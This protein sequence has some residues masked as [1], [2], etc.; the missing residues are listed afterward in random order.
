MLRIGG[1]VS[2]IRR[3]AK[4]LYR[5]KIQAPSVV[6]MKNMHLFA[7]AP[8]SGQPMSAHSITTGWSGFSARFNLGA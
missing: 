2:A 7:Q 1:F 4:S 8:D 3:R 6:W 5:L